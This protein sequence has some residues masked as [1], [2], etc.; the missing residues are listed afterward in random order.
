MERRLNQRLTVIDHKGMPVLFAD[1]TGLGSSE[2]AGQIRQN[3]KDIVSYG[4]RSGEKT[5]LL[6]TDLTDTILLDEVQDAFKELVPAIDPYIKAAAIVGMTGLKR[7]ALELLNRFVSVQ[8]RGFDTVD[9]AKEWLV[10][11]A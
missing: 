5:V 8:R 9:E 11:Q 6:L 2:F 4:Q 10:G 1:Y 3:L 7:F